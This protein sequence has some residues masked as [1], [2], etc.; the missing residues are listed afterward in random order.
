M[1]TIQFY[2]DEGG[3]YESPHEVVTFAALTLSPNRLQG[4]NEDWNALLR[5]YEIPAI[6]M[7]NLANVSKGCSRKFRENRT[8]DQTIEALL[9]FADCINKHLEVGLFEVLDV[10]AY[11]AM[12][13]SVKNKFG[14][15][16]RDPHYLAF[17]RAMVEFQ[18]VISAEDKISL[19]CDDDAIKAF[20]CYL[21]YRAVCE[22][23]PEQRQR[24]IALT[25]AKAA[26]FPVLQAADM[27]A[28]LS[29]LEG[30][31][32]FRGET[33]KWRE[34]FTYLTTEPPP[35]KGLMRWYDMIADGPVLKKLAD[36][37][38]KKES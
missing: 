17:V 30:I 36:S 34:L 25:F 28:L 4:F 22:G 11:I 9:P 20:D 1:T 26:S 16:Y 37:L 15:E 10:R 38:E 13:E 12:P 18:K 6:H 8:V 35:S 29:R 7:K 14:G 3:K 32:R 24:F 23:N 33:N 27:V 31:E 5:A 2:C 21:H 19:I